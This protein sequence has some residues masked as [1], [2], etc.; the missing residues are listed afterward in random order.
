MCD[1]KRVTAGWKAFVEDKTLVALS[2]VLD[3][4]VASKLGNYD[5]CVEH[6]IKFALKLQLQKIDDTLIQLT[7]VETLWKHRDWEVLRQ[8]VLVA[9]GWQGSN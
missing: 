2:E 7:R 1:C 4:L 6:Q 3:Y 8:F 9:V 5:V